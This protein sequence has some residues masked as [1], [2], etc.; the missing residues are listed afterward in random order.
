MF[1]L[2]GKCDFKSTIFLSFLASV[3]VITMVSSD[4][5]EVRDVL[6]VVLRN[7]KMTYRELAGELG[8]TESAVKKIFTAEDSS[9]SRLHQICKV[10]GVSLLDILRE[11]ETKVL[12]QE[13]FGHEAEQFFAKNMDY[14]HFFWR[15]VAE[16]QTPEEM[17]ETD[18]LTEAECLRYLLKLD[19]LG[20]IE[21]HENNVVR[22]PKMRLNRWMGEGPLTDTIHYEWSVSLVRDVVKMT[23]EEKSKHFMLRS[24]ALR[25][26]SYQDFLQ[27]ARDLEIEFLK[28]SQRERSLSDRGLV[29]VRFLICSNTGSFIPNGFVKKK[30]VLRA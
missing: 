4:F 1:T 30:S 3:G 19:E 8:L 11:M 25:P 27:A 9:Y 28:R 7:R 29:N 12:R 20:L 17:R 18:G 23:L 14:F 13:K 22:L 24:I 15:L 26:E 5:R 10:L 16:R 6:K 2:L 21:L